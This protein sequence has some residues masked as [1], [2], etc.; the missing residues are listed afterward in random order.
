MQV[1]IRHLTR[2]GDAYAL[3]IDAAVLDLL[4][5]DETTP[6]EVRT[7][8]T[9]FQIRP[10][11]ASSGAPSAAPAEA[12]LVDARDT[13]RAAGEPEP[14][15]SSRLDTVAGPPPPSPTSAVTVTVTC[16]GRIVGRYPF[17]KDELLIGRNPRAEIHLDDRAL[18]RDHAG[19]S[20]RGASLWIADLGSANGTFIGGERLVAPRLLRA[21]DVVAI[22]RHELR[23]EGMPDGPRDTPVLTITGPDGEH[24]FAMVDTDIV[25]GRGD[26]CDV[27]LQ[28]RSVSRRHLRLS[29]GPVRGTFKATNISGHNVVKV[30]GVPIEGPT[31]FRVG[32]VVELGEFTLVIDHLQTDPVQNDA[33]MAVDRST[34][35]HAAYG[36]DGDDDDAPARAQRTTAERAAPATHADRSSSAERSGQ[37]NAGLAGAGPVGDV[38]DG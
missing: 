33:T 7:D 25:I 10:L 9:G 19:L 15:P 12:T 37:R 2:L 21:S 29:R 14:E 1:M 34:I 28:S 13:E 8:G 35:A 17:V 27:T 18:S 32:E 24:R 3:V 16:N 11:G 31:T 23:I 26:D 6:L 5:I 4:G 36:S 22:G 38:E 20:R 30:V